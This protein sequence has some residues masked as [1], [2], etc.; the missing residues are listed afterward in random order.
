MVAPVTR[1]P[2]AKLSSAELKSPDALE[3]LEELE[4]LQPAGSRVNGV[5]EAST[6]SKQLEIG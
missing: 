1:R 2:L 6:K 4:E 5:E 3:E